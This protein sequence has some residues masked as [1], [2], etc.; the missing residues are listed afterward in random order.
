MIRFSD[1]NLYSNNTEPPD[2]EIQEIDNEIHTPKIIQQLTQCTAEDIPQTQDEE[3]LEPLADIQ[4]MYLPTQLK[5]SNR[6]ISRSMEAESE[7]V[8][9]G[10]QK[11]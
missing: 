11:E 5:S 3:Y 10:M 7:N 8:Q 9:N 1:N 4:N 2:E 6:F